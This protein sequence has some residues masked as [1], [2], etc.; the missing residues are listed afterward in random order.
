[1]IVR[2]GSGWQTVLADLS[3]IL[4]MT[5]A[6]ALGDAPVELPPGAAPP[7]RDS[8]PAL[9]QPIAVWTAGQGA[10]P[11]D[12]WLRQSAIDPRLQLTI[13]APQT[14]ASDALALAAAAGRPARLVLEPGEGPVQALLGYDQAG[15]AQA[16]QGDGA[17]QPRT[18][19][20]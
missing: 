18:P 16:L 10:P 14:A 13:L 11:L 5:T 17:N 2:A 15:L 12:D 8:L 7:A 9:T 3:L 19:A 1:M 20:R 6:A 4:F